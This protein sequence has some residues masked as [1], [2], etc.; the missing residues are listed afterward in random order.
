MTERLSHE[1]ASLLAED[2]GRSDRP[3]ARA[4][5]RARLARNLSE[6]LG[7]GSRAAGARGEVDSA[8]IAAFLDGSMSQ[9][10]R[11]TVAAR[12]ADN[13]VARS[14]MA[15]AA[16]MLDEVDARP[17]AIPAGLVTLAADLLAVAAPGSSRLH[18]TLG[19]PIVWTRRTMVWSG[20]AAAVLAVVAIPAVMTMVWD[21][22][23]KDGGPTERG[24]VATPSGQAKQKDPRSCDDANEA[25]K[26]P[27]QAPD[28]AVTDRD[29]GKKA[30][31]KA[32]QPPGATPPDDDDPCRPKPADGSKRE[33]SSARPN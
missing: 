19:A 31:A 7:Q 4:L 18:S 17:A 9:R 14:E 30:T 12:L 32:N 27:K 10:E 29:A 6:G 24:I 26:T 23:T 3:P 21:G 5:L 20:V 28:D 33:P 8:E 25:A 22:A 11:D 13:P 16:A 2:D 1:L 15:A